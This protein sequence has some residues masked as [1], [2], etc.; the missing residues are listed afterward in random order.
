LVDHAVDDIFNQG[1]IEVYP[2]N[3]LIQYNT[4][5]FRLRPVEQVPPFP[6]TGVLTVLMTNT[7]PL[8]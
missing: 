5:K 4:Q 2:T 3:Y 7:S 1:R 6:V 8:S